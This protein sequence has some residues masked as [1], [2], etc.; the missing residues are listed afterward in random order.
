MTDAPHVE[1]PRLP[2][3]VEEPRLD[4]TGREPGGRRGGVG[5]WWQTTTA[6]ALGLSLGVVLLASVWLLAEAIALVILGIVIGEA[7]SPVVDWL[8]RRI[9]R[10]LAILLTYLVLA[11]ILVGFG[12]AILPTLITQVQT[13]VAAVPGLVEM[14]QR[15]FARLPGV[16][17][18]DI[19]G[20]I[21]SVLGEVSQALLALPGIIVTSLLNI[22]FIVF[23]SVYWLLQAKGRRIFTLSL[24]PKERRERVRYT[25]KSMAQAMGG[26]VRATIIG[27]L[28]IATLYFIGLTIF[29]IP[30]A[31]ALALFAGLME[32][33]PVIGPTLAAIPMV[34]L[35]LAE[36][37]TRALIVL[38]FVLAMQQFES[39]V[40]MPNVVRS[41]TEVSPLLA[42]L[43]LFAGVSLGG[44]L[45]ALVAIPLAAAARVF[46]VQVIAPGI[47]RWT[48][49]APV[50]SE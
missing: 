50:E 39:N 36:S 20:F 45:G 19:V 41:Q 48:G 24:F 18:T 23:V 42:L 4:G 8:G 9:P 35:A 1:V 29:G 12:L 28:I 38:A 6:I 26:F 30:F 21:S 33:I 16:N 22:L 37:P 7:L 27:G 2:E 11:L 34:A 47:R 31:L 32:F 49:A 25:A 14:A 3:R 40:I 13:A 44:L 10:L 5:P 17:T 43:S 46:F 15:W